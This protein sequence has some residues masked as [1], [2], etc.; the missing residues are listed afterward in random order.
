[1]DYYWI[2]DGDYINS[3]TSW[4]VYDNST[5]RWGLNVFLEDLELYLDSGMFGIDT[6]G[7]LLIAFII[8]FLFVG[9]MS[10]KF[11]FVSPMAITTL[12][13]GV[14]F[15]LDVVTPIL[16]DIRGV[17]NLPTFLAGLI[18]VLAIINEVRQR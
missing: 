15:L 4:L 1:M 9:I 12:I 3:T 17:S 14:V 8:M 11:G 7:R 2:I 18:L 10:Y 6:F 16:P 13:F 5:S